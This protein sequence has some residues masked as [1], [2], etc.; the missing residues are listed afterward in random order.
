MA[1]MAKQLPAGILHSLQSA[2]LGLQDERSSGFED[3]FAQAQGRVLK[4]IAFSGLVEDHRAVSV[5]ETG[6]Q[7]LSLCVFTF[8]NRFSSE[9]F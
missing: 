5:F 4:D 6:Y 8:E 7:R 1:G 2:N 3:L 9:G